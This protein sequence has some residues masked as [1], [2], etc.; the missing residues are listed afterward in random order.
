MDKKLILRYDNEGDI[1]YV[2]AIEPYAEQN[3]EEI[4]QG[5]IAR[6]NPDNGEIENLEVLFFNARLKRGERLELPLLSKP[7]V[8]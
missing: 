8:A 5:V 1:L 4:E 7:E 2:D 6:L 3:S